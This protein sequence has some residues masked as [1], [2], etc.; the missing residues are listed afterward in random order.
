[1]YNFYIIKASIMAQAVL[2]VKHW[3]NSL[4]VRLPTATAKP[5]NL[6]ANQ[7]VKLS[8]EADSIIITPIKE[9]LSDKLAHFDP[10]R[11]VAR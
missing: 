2:Q 3:G 6:H 1:M 7:Q 9:A 4:G 8:V 5:H 11:T 10:E